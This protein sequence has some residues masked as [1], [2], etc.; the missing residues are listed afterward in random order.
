MVLTLVR[1]AGS[2][3]L[4]CLLLAACG[5]ERGSI[6]AQS[7]ALPPD[8]VNTDESRLLTVY[9]TPTCGCCGD[10]VQHLETNGFSSRVN[11]PDDLNA[12]KD[13]FGI[14]PELQSCHTAVSADGYVFEGHIPARYIHQFLASPP[15]DA[16]GLSVPGMPVGS[17]GMEVGDKFMAYQVLLLKR[18]GS[19][20]TY[21]SVTSADEQ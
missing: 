7:Q 15:K 10:W 13:R 16:V 2:G 21:A 1:P 18:D 9:K 20:E 6:T 19:I 8:A 4:L 14:K 12:I 11:H 17:P 5:P 3:L